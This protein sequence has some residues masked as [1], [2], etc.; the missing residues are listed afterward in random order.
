MVVL[1][2]PTFYII[3]FGSSL[4]DCHDVDSRDRDCFLMF[5]KHRKY[6]IVV[7]CCNVSVLFLSFSDACFSKCFLMLMEPQ[8]ALINTANE[9][10][11]DITQYLTMYLDDNIKEEKLDL[12]RDALVQPM[13]F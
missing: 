7:T 6:R 11:T 10:F 2:R 4:P 3:A 5:P 12:F 9:L 8:I 13:L 1:V